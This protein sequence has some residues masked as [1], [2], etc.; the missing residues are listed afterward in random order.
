MATFQ[1]YT[2]TK[3][4]MWERATFDIEAETYNQALE[5]ALKC[6]KTGGY[7]DMTDYETLYDT[8]ESMS[9]L[10]N[11]GVATKELYHV[12][13]SLGEPVWDNKNSIND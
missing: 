6:A 12:P 3:V 1:F 4:T 9:V 13:D 8:A 2:D 11:K 7:P 5:Q 10:D